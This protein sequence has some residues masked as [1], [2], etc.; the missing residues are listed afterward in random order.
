MLKSLGAGDLLVAR[1]TDNG[2]DHALTVGV[3]N[4]VEVSIGGQDGD[5]AVGASKVDSNNDLVKVQVESPS[6]VQCESFF[7]FVDF[8][9]VRSRTR[10]VTV[11]VL[12]KR[13]L[14]CEKGM[15]HCWR[16]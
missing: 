6:G 3:G 4:D 1:E 8:Q 15:R 5:G 14:L 2:G 16:G 11:I 12:G 10:G 13:K 9:S 7:L